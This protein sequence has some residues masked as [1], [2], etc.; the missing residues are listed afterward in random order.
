VSK[1]AGGGAGGLEPLI[2][3][4]LQGCAYNR[5]DMSMES[6]P[7]RTPRQR[8]EYCRQRLSELGLDGYWVVSHANVRYLSGFTGGDS[9]LLVNRERS[10]LIT[11]S[12]FEEQA[13][14]EAAVDEIVCRR[15][16][17]AATVATLCRKMGLRRITVTARHVSHADWVTLTGELPA[18]KVEASAA[19]LADRMRMRKSREE[20]EAIVAATKAA[21]DG[22]RR[23]LGKVEAGRSEKWLAATLEWEMK[24]AGAE[25]AAFETICAVDERASLPH[26]VCTGR[27]LGAESTLLVDWG[28]RLEGYHCDLTRVVGVST[29][30]PRIAELSQVVLEAQQAAFDRL[31]PGVPC[32]EVD[33]AARTVI[34]RAGYGHHFGHSLGHGVGLEV[35]ELPRLGA[36]EK[37]MLL[38]GMV[39]TVE[40][41][42]YLPGVGGV[43]VEDLVI[44]TESGH[45]VISSL[46]KLPCGD[47]GSS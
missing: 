13:Q 3:A 2:F 10:V 42:V 28:A 34:A 29:M 4:V 45:E 7:S 17:M 14:Q 47:C 20:A 16:G 27:Q 22:F 41:A 36:G 11:D 12:R 25:A 39:V 26:A 21:E 5:P 15:K 8:A 40:P 23:F 30:P 9:T 43:R 32:C 31:K 38:P 37:E 44:V 1:R 6:L 46:D 18:A 24:A 33:Q 35:H 19:G